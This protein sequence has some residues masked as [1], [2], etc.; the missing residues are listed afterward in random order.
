MTD[1]LPESLPKSQLE[2]PQISTEKI[3]TQPKKS[4]KKLWVILSIL[5]AAVIVGVIVCIFVFVAV[6]NAVSVEKGP[7]EAV[8]DTFMK[9]MVAK[10]TDNAYALFSPRMKGQFPE[11]KLVELI[12][13]NNYVLF[14]GYQNL[15]IENLKISA[16]VNANPDLPQGTV[17]TVSG[18]IGYEGG[19]TGTFTGTF[20]KVEGHWLI[21]GINIT[22]PP[23]KFK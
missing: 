23:D 4:R 3:P 17:A 7:V 22:V 10:D 5:G 9:R 20:E 16:V 21:Y 14:E 6:S 11:S 15:S 19:F 12:Q 18:T 8:I 1:E 13:G 2:N